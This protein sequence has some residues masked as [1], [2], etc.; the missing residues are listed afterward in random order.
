MLQP[1]L[2][3]LE[4]FFWGEKN[5]RINIFYISKSVNGVINKVILV[6]KANEL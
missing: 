4:R 5:T 3:E 2:F 6:I 1:V